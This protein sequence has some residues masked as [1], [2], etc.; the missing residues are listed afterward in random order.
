MKRSLL[1]V[2]L[3]GAGGRIP[4]AR[5]AHAE[6]LGL[7]SAAPRGGESS[8]HMALGDVASEPERIRSMRSWIRCRRSS[9][10]CDFWYRA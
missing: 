1:L 4:V 5:L 6:S 9:S 3:F 8:A 2:G 10:T 7:G